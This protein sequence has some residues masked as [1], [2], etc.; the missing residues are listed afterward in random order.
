VYSVS[1]TGASNPPKLVTVTVY[2]ACWPSEIVRVVG[3]IVTW[4][5]CAEAVPLNRRRRMQ[6]R[7]M[8]I[9]EVP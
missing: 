9:M 4:K 7:I 5:L 8:G 6:R 1:A 3:D 2:V